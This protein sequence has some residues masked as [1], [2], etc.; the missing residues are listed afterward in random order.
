MSQDVIAAAGLTRAGDLY[1]APSASRALQNAGLTTPEDFRGAVE[2]SKL[3]TRG[4]DVTLIRRIERNAGDE[5]LI[6]YLKWYAPLPWH[7][8][9]FRH[10][11]GRAGSGALTELHHINRLRQ[12]GIEV[13]RPLAFG[14]DVPL[15]PFRSF[16][17]LSSL[18]HWTTL[19]EIAHSQRF[20]TVL[21]RID[22][23]RRLIA[24]VADL[25]RRMHHANIANPSLYS[26][27]VIVES[28]ESDPVRLGLIDLEDLEVDVRVDDRRRAAD[29]GALA[30]TL[31]RESVSRT[32]RARFVRGYYRSDRLDSV[33]R[34]LIRRVDVFYERNRHRRR[35]RHYSR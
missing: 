1:L 3:V 9:A 15:G 28:L 24:A 13:P 31:Q 25:A 16:L 2:E 14:Q 19:E 10:L 5:S 30:L 4:D 33:G 8:R 23:R 6:A 7:R 32:D 17:L 12:S 21:A 26:R 29:L 22:V 27:H 20:E 11:R 35:F 34:D 18:E